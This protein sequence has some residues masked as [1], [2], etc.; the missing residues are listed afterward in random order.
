M[1]LGLNKSRLH[2]PFQLVVISLSLFAGNFLGHHHAGR[3]F[4]MTAHA[5]FASYLW[6]Y[7]VLQAGLGVF[8]KMH[9]LEHTKVRGTLKTLHKWVGISFPI[10]GWVQMVFGVRNIRSRLPSSAQE[11]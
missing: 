7:V 1:I 4:H 6:W 8:L 10:V 2:V 3:S 5:S 11:C 9:V